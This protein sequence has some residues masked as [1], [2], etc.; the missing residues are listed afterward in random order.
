[1]ERAKAM[2]YG[3][4]KMKK[5]VKLMTGQ[6]FELYLLQLR[7]MGMDNDTLNMYRKQIAEMLQAEMHPQPFTAIDL[8]LFF[9]GTDKPGDTGTD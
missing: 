2:N 6:S 1:M 8:E 5:P 9:T 3:Q 4:S 7:N